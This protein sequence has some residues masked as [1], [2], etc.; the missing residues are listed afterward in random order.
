MC[1]VY[2]FGHKI[3]TFRAYVQIKKCFCAQKS[4][5]YTFIVRFFPANT[6]KNLHVPFFCCTFAGDLQS[7]WCTMQ[8]N[9]VFISILLACTM[10]LKAAQATVAVAANA[11]HT[12]TDAEVSDAI[13]ADAAEMEY[14]LIGWTTAPIEDGSCPAT[15]YGLHATVRPETATT[16]YAFFARR[17]A[18]GERIIRRA[19]DPA[20]NDTVLL[21]INQGSAY[22]VAPNSSAGL[23]SDMKLTGKS[24]FFSDNL[25][26][27]TDEDDY[28]FRYEVHDA[29]TF[30]LRAAYRN[31]PLRY[32]YTESSL[33]K[34]RSIEPPI[35]VAAHKY[36]FVLKNGYIYN[37]N[38]GTY[39]YAVVD[40]YSRI[41]WRMANK[42]TL[43]ESF[44]FYR[45]ERY[46]DFV[47]DI[48]PC[49]NC[50]PYT[51]D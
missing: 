6:I 1:C 34:V 35:I 25:Y 28:V 4:V 13:R 33:V 19:N 40:E 29:D 21:V 51:S 39:A 31:A 10:S 16:Y 48:A 23:I 11:S 2:K 41:M 24:S 37:K 32:L 3:T 15:Y 18:S 42:N 30:K 20:D 27:G 17:A 45:C 50:F 14:T 46:Q 9:I 49:P 47:T 5:F 7:I 8:K 44:Y 26:I 36:K 12:F 22:Y 38:A 43:G